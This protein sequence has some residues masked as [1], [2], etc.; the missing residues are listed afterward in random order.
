ML[1]LFEKKYKK[2]TNDDFIKRLRSAV[3][4]EGM[5]HEGNIYLMDFSLKNIPRS[6]SIIEIGCYG[7]LSTNLIC[8]LLRKHQKNNQ[9]F[10]SDLWIYEGY[11]DANGGVSEFMDGRN[12]VYR[13]DFMN[14]IK[15][16]FIASTRLLS[17]ANLPFTMHLSSFDFL[18]KWDKNELYEDV[19]GRKVQLGGAVAFAYIDGNHAYDFVSREFEIIDKHLLNGGFL[20]LDDSFDGCKMGSAK[21]A[22]ELLQNPDYKVVGCN[23]NYLF[24]KK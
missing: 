6:G 18:E 10:G 24:Q 2:I 5:L 21:F 3:I 20:L 12:D 23:P 22:R 19:F 4:G 16:S 15:N 9:F 11:N 8:Y 13:T 14:H 7:G 1:N 17:S